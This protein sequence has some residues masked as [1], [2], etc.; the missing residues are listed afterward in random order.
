MASVWVGLV[1]HS[2]G[3]AVG[4]AVW[5]PNNTTYSTV[6]ILITGLTPGALQLDWATAVTSGTGTVTMRDGVIASGHSGPG[7]M[8]VWA[9]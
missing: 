3:A 7:L 8:E 1:N 5:A 6:S 9:A 2:G 4:A